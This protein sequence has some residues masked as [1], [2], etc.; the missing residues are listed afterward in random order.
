MKSIIFFI[1]FIII[2][3]AELKIHD[4]YDLYVENTNAIH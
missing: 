1:K 4:K 3:L 2:F